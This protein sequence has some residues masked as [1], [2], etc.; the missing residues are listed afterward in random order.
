MKLSCVRL[1]RDGVAVLA[2]RSKWVSLHFWP[3][4]TACGGFNL[5]SMNTGPKWISSWLIGGGC[6][7]SREVLWTVFAAYINEYSSMRTLLVSQ[8]LNTRLGVVL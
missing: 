5:D 4:L 1:L 8:I 2:L 6:L 3:I 7:G